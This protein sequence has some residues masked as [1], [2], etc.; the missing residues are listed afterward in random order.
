MEK[1][2]WKQSAGRKRDMREH[3]DTCETQM[4]S[5]KI[6]WFVESDLWAIDWD[7]QTIY[8]TTKDVKGSLLML[9]SGPASR[10]MAPAKRKCHTTDSH[11]CWKAKSFRIGTSVHEKLPRSIFR[12]CTK[13][14]FRFYPN[15]YIYRRGHWICREKNIERDS[16]KVQLLCLLQFPLGKNLH[17]YRPWA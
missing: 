14:I 8:P 12:S 15:L 3:M 9:G 2:N 16:V 4:L 7:L 5:R 17:Y 6:W 11:H 10:R 13:G 1:L